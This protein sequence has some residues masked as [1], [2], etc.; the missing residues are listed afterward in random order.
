VYQRNPC[1]SLQKLM[2]VQPL[3]E[4][5]QVQMLHWRGIA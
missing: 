2:Q 3:K 1:E 4:Q 5:E